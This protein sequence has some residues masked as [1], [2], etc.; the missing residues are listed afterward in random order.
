M[1]ENLYLDAEMWTTTMHEQQAAVIRIEA[2]FYEL[3][4]EYF[5]QECI[6]DGFIQGSDAY[7]FTWSSPKMKK[8]ILQYLYPDMPK[9]ISTVKDYEK[10][11]KSILEDEDYEG[12]SHIYVQ[13]LLNRNFEVI[14]NYLI[15]GHR[16]WLL[17]QN[18]Y[19]P[20]DTILINLN[21]PAQKLI[22]FSHIDPSI[23]STDKTV[24][25][26]MKH[27]LAAKLKEYNKATKMATSYGQNFLNTINPDGM[28]RIPSITSILN[29]GRSSMKLYQL[30]PGNNLYR[31]PFNPNNPK[32]GVRE[33]GHVW[34]LAGAD[35]CSQELAVLATFANEPV[36]IDALENGYD[37]HSINTARLFPEKWKALGGEEKPKGK[38]EDKT[39]QTL[40][41]NT[42]ATI[43]GIAYGKSA[44]GL[45]ESLNIP[46]TTEDIIEQNPEAFK[47]YMKENK[48]AFKVFCAEFN[49]GKNTKKAIHDF[50][51][52][53][54][55]ENRFLPDVVS[56]QDLIDRVFNALPA[57][58][59]F[60]HSSA[61]QGAIQNYIRTPDFFSRLR[62][63]PVPEGNTALNR[64]KRASQNYGI[65]GSSAN[66]T[67][68]AICLIKKHIEDNNLQDKIKFALPLHDELQYLVRGDFAEE[69]LELVINKMEE[70]AEFILENKLLK[71]EGSITDTWE[72]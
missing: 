61:E 10:Y 16:K 5:L 63:F 65:Q 25:A 43:F 53:E 40:R 49:N 45:G 27:P 68:Y 9:N 8:E 24:I 22:L 48:E 51:K 62:K 72:K 71:A 19:V 58:A 4:R 38:P 2:E 6:E 31:N 56:G 32:T 12:R 26:K 52:R 50:I 36:M 33:D 15:G 35:Y 1:C 67:K 29:T 66:C 44:V 60:L 47:E 20:K 14:E 54:H 39:L 7:N 28:M 42:K 69:G 13:A 55:M 30:L 41:N 11:L 17:Q 37:L 18:I 59:E 21:S 70:A 57:M 3:M 64:I 34:K 23:T 46:G